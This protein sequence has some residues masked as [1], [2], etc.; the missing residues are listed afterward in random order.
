MLNYQRVNSLCKPP[1][2][3]R[4]AALARETT[5]AEDSEMSED[6]TDTGWRLKR[7]N[8]SRPISIHRR[9]WVLCVMN[10]CLCHFLT[11]NQMMSSKCCLTNFCFPVQ[12]QIWGILN[13]PAELC[14]W[15]LAIFWRTKVSAS[16][17][18]SHW[19]VLI[20]SPAGHG[21]DSSKILRKNWSPDV[22]HLQIWI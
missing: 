7:G 6:S 2:N 21:G 1:P 12:N 15:H 17:R 16:H 5:I 4:S 18:G 9:L 13:Y 20:D 11:Q 8:A 10:L 19:Q 22:N 3:G 14:H